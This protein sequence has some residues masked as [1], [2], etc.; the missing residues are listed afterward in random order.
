MKKLAILATG[1]LLAFAGWALA[2]GVPVPQIGA[3][4]QT[5]SV[6]VVPLSAPSA[7]AVYAPPGGVAGIEQY[8]YQVPLTAF[9]ITV[10]KFVSFLYLNP[11]GTLATGTITMPASPGDGQRVCVEDSQTQTAVTM[12]A[13]TGQ[14]FAAFGLGTVTALTANTK[15]CWMFNAPL[16]VWIRTT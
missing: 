6:Q 8:S 9:T 3:I 11:A 15:Y 16:A 10:P 1:A 14:A 13:N 2:Q 12:T 4:S 5:D 7:Q